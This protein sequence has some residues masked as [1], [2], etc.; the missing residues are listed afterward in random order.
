MWPDDPADVRSDKELSLYAKDNEKFYYRNFAGVIR[1]LGGGT[2]VHTPRY[3]HLQED[4]DFVGTRWSLDRDQLVD[5]YDYLY[6]RSVRDGRPVDNLG[7]LCE[8]SCHFYWRHLPSSWSIQSRLHRYPEARIVLHPSRGELTPNGEDFMIGFD[9]DA[10]IDT[11]IPFSPNTKTWAV[12]LIVARRGG[13]NQQPRHG[14]LPTHC[15]LYGRRA[16]RSERLP[17]RFGK[18][19]QCGHLD[20]LRISADRPSHL[21][22]G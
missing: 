20:E 9:T 15:H 5:E 17:P 21:R 16:F 13:R 22:R 10:G 14:R 19:R 8:W 2:T 18:H 4:T 3:R 12:L 7:H 1:E 6:E 11:L